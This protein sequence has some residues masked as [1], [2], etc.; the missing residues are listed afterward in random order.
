LLSPFIFEF[1]IV[2]ALTLLSQYL[3]SSN[4]AF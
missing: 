3:K 1:G 2:I 4:I